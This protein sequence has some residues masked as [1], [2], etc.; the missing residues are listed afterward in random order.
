MK[1]IFNLVLFSIF[2]SLL[3]AQIL[4]PVSI[5]LPPDF[6]QEQIE[7]AIYLQFPLSHFAESDLQ[8]TDRHETPGGQYWHFQQ[9]FRGEPIYQA[10]VKVKINS[11]NRIPFFLNN[12]K[13][14]SPA[15]KKGKA[16]FSLTE[17]G[18]RVH[19]LKQMPAFNHHAEAIWFPYDG[20]LLA[21]YLVRSYAHAGTES[22]ELILDAAT[23][24]ELQRRDIRAYHSHQIMADTS[25]QGRVFRPNPC[26][27]AGASY[28]TLFSNN[29]DMHLPV[30]ETYMDTIV[31]KGLTY[32][33]G[34]FLLE[35]PYVKLM[36]FSIP[37][38]PPVTSPDG[39]FFFNR[40]ETGFEDVMAYYHIDTFQRYVQS[41]GYTDLYS[42]TPIQ[43]DAHGAGGTDQSSFSTNG[44]ILYGTNYAAS[45][46]HVD[47]AE[48]ADVII[49]EYGHAL[50][51]AASPNTRGGNQRVGLDE[52]YGDYFAAA[53]SYDIRSDYGWADIFNWDGHNE[54]WPG[55]IANSTRK[56]TTTGLGKYDYAEIWSSTM[57]RLRQDIGATEC[58]RLQ[59]EVLYGGANGLTFPQA[60][61]LLLYADTALFGG[62]YYP[63]ITHRF[64]E[65]EVVTGAVCLGV[66]VEDDIPAA[67]W[68]VSYVKGE[69]IYAKI[70]P[71]LYTPTPKCFFRL[72]NTLGQLI[73]EK[74]F[75]EDHLIQFS[76]LAKGM[77]ILSLWGEDGMKDSRKVVVW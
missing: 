26:T 68:T 66:D 51:H 55:R 22:Y 77:Y 64:C 13:T 35:G 60:Y 76:S 70:I 34:Q 47:D 6:T 3:Q 74:P 50:S 5:S 73:A 15:A 25:G 8:L 31:L 17:I 62:M 23:G 14:T 54:F 38:V 52:G 16:R 12:L 58:D 48:D 37:N 20:E 72:T 41:L 57:M 18:I 45:N 9:T 39:N 43:I 29:D 67:N 30:F 24:E 7:S 56:Y 49:H 46:E 53:Y 32:E 36:E 59:L 33:N 2:C 4:Q 71:G 21:A 1:R 19:L 44:R 65:A 40:N 10:D 69:G 75:S 11:D 61:Q 42:T 63:Q 28:G 27:A